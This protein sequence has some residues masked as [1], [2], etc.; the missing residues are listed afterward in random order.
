M[1]IRR[2]KVLDYLS[3]IVVLLLSA[4]EKEVMVTNDK[5]PPKEI[6]PKISGVEID[7]F[8]GVASGNTFIVELFANSIIDLKSIKMEQIKFLTNN[9]SV[10][11]N[12]EGPF[13][14]LEAT[15]NTIPFIA[16]IDGKTAT[17]NLKVTK[18]KVD[19]S[20]WIM[21][22]NGSSEGW[23]K[24]DSYNG[25][26]LF[27]NNKWQSINWQS[28]EQT[29]EM[30]GEL[31]SAGINVIICDLTNAWPR[32]NNRA[33]FILKLCE[34]NGMKACVAE[35]TP[36]GDVNA[37]ELKA[38]S[39]YDNFAGPSAPYS[40]AYFKVNGKPLIVSYIP[41]PYYLKYF[42]STGEYR[43]KFEV[44]NAG[45]ENETFPDRWGWQYEF[46]K[47]LVASDNAMFVSP[48]TKFYPKINGVW[49][50]W[51]KHLAYLD[52]NFTLAKF[53]S[54]KN[55]IV[56]SFDDIHERNGWM[57]MRT[58]NANERGQQTRNIFGELD[59]VVYY[60]RV[61]EWINS[62]PSSIP[63]GIVEDG[64]YRLLTTDNRQVEV[65]DQNG[66][67]GILLR[68]TA[69]SD[70]RKSLFYFYHLGGNEYRI[71]SLVA[72]LSV[73]PGSDNVLSQQWDTNSDLQRW[74][75]VKLENG[76]FRFKN[77]ST[78]KYIG[79]KDWNGK[80]YLVQQEPLEN[81]ADQEWI[82]DPALT[83]SGKGYMLQK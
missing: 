43:S 49:T 30:V 25:V 3:V 22:W 14:F 71:V 54:P 64:A 29:I 33:N 34:Q 24:P 59:S 63:N 57:V 32:F 47:G 79:L 80:D 28:D 74:V 16:E 69:V 81:A 82:L 10:K 27:I 1:K 70:T 11:I 21:V 41:R 20:T 75:L 60:N 61:H 35:N 55:I 4:C 18:R 42:E 7:N 56:S 5:F 37:F 17:Y 31:K 36:N 2:I 77:K 26:Q 62:T 40:S 65:K 44:V 72:G 12:T 6:E 48:S 9:K 52:Y 50:C 83:L 45:G 23:W 66:T 19:Y 46:E 51:R 15:N 76:R 8:K 67:V 39:I 53:K 73:E 68:K 38:K 58:N 78:Q 13:N